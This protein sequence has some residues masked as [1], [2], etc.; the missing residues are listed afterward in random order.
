M[1]S[2]SILGSAVQYCS[3]RRGAKRAR[4]EQGAAG[5]AAAGAG[6]PCEPPD[7][8]CKIVNDTE[9]LKEFAY[10]AVHNTEYMQRVLII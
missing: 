6:E 5:G 2:T 3:P 1:R 9:Y 4:G 10:K 7:F 8:A